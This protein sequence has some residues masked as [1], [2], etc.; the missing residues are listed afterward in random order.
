M[1]QGVGWIEN[2]LICD[3]KTGGE[4]IEMQIVMDYGARA[5]G[6]IT[7]AIWQTVIIIISSQWAGQ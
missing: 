3:G 1:Q 6:W 2:D 4:W 5:T 7:I